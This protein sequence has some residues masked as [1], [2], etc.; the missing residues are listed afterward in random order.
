MKKDFV[1]FLIRLS[2]YSVLIYGVLL[3]AGS[4]IPQKFYYQHPL[5][6]VVFFFTVTAAFHFGM[7][8]RAE[9]GGRSIVT[10][11]M[12]A[13]VLKFLIYMGVM[14]AYALMKPDRATA[15]ISSFFAVYILMTVFEGSVIYSH[16]KSKSPLSAGN[17]VKK[18]H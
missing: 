13:T 9:K 6:L 3:I 8:Q 5:Y 17:K 1:Q 14:I 7:T 2:I 10:Y 12:M 4:T 15:F 18:E 11:F 16:F